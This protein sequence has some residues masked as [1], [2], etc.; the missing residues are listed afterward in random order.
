MALR[1]AEK[2]LQDLGI[3]DPA[4][5]DLEAIAYHVGAE[6]RYRALQGCEARIVGVG[7]RAI[8]TVNT[9]GTTARKRFSIAHE[10]GHWCHHRGQCHACRAEDYRPRSALSPERVADD[11][12]SD[13]LLPNYLFRDA[14]KKA[15]KLS[16]RAIGSLA[17]IFSTSQTATAIRL[18]ETDHTPALLICHGPQGRKWFTQ[19]PSVPRRWFPQQD[20][21]ADSFAFGVLFGSAANDAMPRKVGADAWFDRREA[22]RYEL[23]EQTFR[24]GKDEIL[25]LV[26]LSDDRMLEEK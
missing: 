14:S 18:V 11:Y 24:V 1:P 13:L 15:G 8:I 21:H 25:T 26:I 20:L 5:I 2:L 7:D 9:N 3:T 22:E 12:A 17:E 10:L 16:F 23:H 4:E 19:A 6:I